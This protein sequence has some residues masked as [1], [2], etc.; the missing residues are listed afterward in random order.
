VP[1][2]VHH[3]WT[4]VYRKNNTYSVYMDGIEVNSGTIQWT[5]GGGAS[6]TPINMYFLF[7]GTWGHTQVSSV[8]HNL[9]ASQFSGKYYEWD[10]SRVYLRP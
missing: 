2:D 6:S 8:N 9:S 3:T 4:W 5:L 7:D 10:Y 1:P